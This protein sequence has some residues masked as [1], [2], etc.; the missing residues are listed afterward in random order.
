MVSTVSI[1]ALE[2]Y[3]DNVYEAIII[4]AKRARQINEEQK[5]LIQQEKDADEGFSDY[6]EEEPEI[7]S[8]REYKKFPKPTTLALSEFLAGKIAYSYRSEENEQEE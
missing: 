5:R 7:L 8:P 3:A 2:K 6:D 1:D 4:L